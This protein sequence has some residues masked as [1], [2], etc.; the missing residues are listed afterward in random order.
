MS[1]DLLLAGGEIVFPG[2]GVRTGSVAVKDGRIAA[3]LAPGEQASARQVIDCRGKWVMPGLIDPHTHIGFGSNETDFETESRSAAIGGVTG[4]MTFHRSNDLRQSTGPWKERGE[5]QS[6]IDFGFHFGVT[7]KLH[8]ETLPDCAEHFGVTSIK[9]Y[10]MYKGAS[11]AAK[12]FTEIDDGLLY[13]A[14]LQGARIKGGVVGV[15]CENVEVIPVFREPLKAAGRNDLPVWDEQSPGFL[16]AENV[17]RVIYFGEKAQCP[18]NIVH[19]SSAESLEIVRRAKRPGRAPIHVETCS[20]Y[21]ALTSQSP[22]GFLGKVNPPLRSAT[23]VEALWEGV[24]DGTISTIGSDHVPRKRETKGPDIWKASAGF[25][26]IGTLLPVLIHEGVHKRDLPIEQI[27]AVTSAN[28]AKLYSIPN[29]G[30]IAVGM[31]ADL[32]VVD[33]DKE[34]VV[35]P[36]TQESF[37]DY[38]PYEGMRFKGAPVRTILRGRVIASDGAVDP[39]ARATPAGRYLHR[40]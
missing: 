20:H 12:G 26:G 8:I 6:L 4:M 24:R 5:S 28:V 11:G 7:S 31:D 38:S 40:S 23:D 2:V 3:L 35:D 10:L 14:L 9:V 29:K 18:V 25:P 19:M 39:Q 16:E 33:P 1:F 32:V 15:H 13:R 21:L 30:H 34:I 27:A 36:S 37:S 17:F 22:I